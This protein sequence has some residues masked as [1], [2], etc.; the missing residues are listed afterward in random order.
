MLRLVQMG[1]MSPSASRVAEFAGVSLRTVFRHFEDMDALYREMT[2]ALE[3]ELLPIVRAPYRRRD[4]RGRLEELLLRRA[5]IYERIMPFKTAAGLRRYASTYLR[6]DYE[7]FSRFERETLLSALPSRIGGDTVRFA[8]L[9]LVS[10]FEAWRALRQDMG[11]STELARETVRLSVE[12][13]I[14]GV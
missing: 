11:R 13:L 8:A 7:R 12:Q 14:A 6:Q 2:A 1:D 3:N 10:G 4:W 5:E 9:E